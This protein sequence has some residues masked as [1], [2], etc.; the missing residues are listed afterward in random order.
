[1]TRWVEIE[2]DCLPLR[3]IGRWDPPLDASASQR[4]LCW[5]I[6]HA[7]EKHGT[8]NTYYLYNA[9]C[10]FHMTNRPERGMIEFLFEGIVITDATDRH[11]VG[12]DLDIRLLRETCDWLTE[13]V[14]HWL[15]ETVCRAVEIEFDRFAESG[16][17]EK[18][19]RRIEQLEKDHAER[20]GF[21][22][23]YL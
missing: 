12:N 23:M 8:H 17:L 19:K 1:M 18:T 10:T 5:R 20:G 13:P 9:H 4:E 14:V 16:D 2:F 22:G 21:L 3:S 15:H 7:A 6:K 11:A